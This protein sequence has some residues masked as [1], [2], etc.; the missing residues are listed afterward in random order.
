MCPAFDKYFCIPKFIN[1]NSM[2][3]DLHKLIV[4]FLNENSGSVR[5]SGHGRFLTN[6]SEF[7]VRQLSYNSTLYCDSVIE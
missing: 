6:T 2:F 1:K 5:R 3:N 4:V 7:S